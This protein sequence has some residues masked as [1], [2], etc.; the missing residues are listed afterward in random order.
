MGVEHLLGQC[1]VDELLLG[2]KK[3]WKD[4]GWSIALLKMENEF[5][6]K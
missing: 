6:A 5:Q 4:E 2:E 1:M 3:S